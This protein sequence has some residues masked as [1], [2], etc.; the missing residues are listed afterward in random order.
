MNL[1]CAAVDDVSATSPVSM[2]T[3]PV[4]LE[5]G[6]C[7]H[8]AL[9]RAAAVR[10]SDDHNTYRFLISC[11]L[12]QGVITSPNHPGNYPDNIDKIEHIIV[13]TG[14]ILRLCCLVV[15][16]LLLRLCENHRWGRDDL[17]GQQLRL[18]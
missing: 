6:R 7:H 4:T 12:T 14:K 5:F 13:E 1:T 3:Q 16:W 8:F 10:V 18:L 11:C 2:T 15:W 9:L 17:D